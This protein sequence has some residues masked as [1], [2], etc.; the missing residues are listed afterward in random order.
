MKRIL[1]TFAFALM[2]TD[3]WADTGKSAQ[4]TAVPLFMAVVVVATLAITAWASRRSKSLS[5]F[6]AA[7]GTIKGW[8]NGV[9]IAGDALPWRAPRLCRTTST[10]TPTAA[11]SD[12]RP[13][14]RSWSRES[15]P[16]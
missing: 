6:Y 4:S 7:G 8:Q 15:P 12:L 1:V 14:A 13:A 5:E 2:A 9:A 10:P 11:I 16:S 3:A